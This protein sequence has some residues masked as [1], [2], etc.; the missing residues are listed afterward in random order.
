ML[1]SGTDVCY[2]FLYIDDITITVS[3]HAM[4]SRLLRQLQGELAMI[5]LDELHFFL[6][7]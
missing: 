7:I 1:H 3:F 4:P 2:L 5:G 6:D